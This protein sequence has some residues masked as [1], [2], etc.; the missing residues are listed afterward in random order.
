MLVLRKVNWNVIEK[1]LSFLGGD[2]FKELVI[3]FALGIAT[4]FFSLYNYH[5]QPWTLD[6]AFITF[7]Y[8]E[9]FVEGKGI[10]YNPGEYVEGYTCFLWLI[11]L[12]LVKKLGFDIVIASKVLG[13][14]FTFLSLFLISRTHKIVKD[15]PWFVSFVSVLVLGSFGT[16]TAWAM[17]GM[18]TS[19]TGF[20]VLCVFLLYGAITSRRLFYY[21]GHFLV[22]VFIALATMARIDAGIILPPILLCAGYEALRKGRWSAPIL[23]VFGF[24]V[25]YFPYFL[26]RYYYYGWLLPNTFYVKVGSSW[27]QIKRGFD[28][29]KY[30][31]LSSSILW[32]PVIFTQ[33]VSVRRWGN[34]YLLIAGMGIAVIFQFLYVVI[35]GGDCMPAYR[36][37]APVA[38][39][40]AMLVGYGL[41]IRGFSRWRA[42]VVLLIIVCF[43]L[44]QCYNDKSLYDRILSDRVAEI[45]KESGEWL[46]AN[47]PPDSLLATNTAGSVA[48]YSRL[49]V[50]DMLGL[51]DEHIAHRYIPSLGKGYA[52][53]EKG[54]GKYVLSRKP[55]YIMFGSASGSKTPRFLSDKEMAGDKEFIENYVYRTHSLPSGRVLHIYERKK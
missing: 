14:I 34:K 45:G 30:F 9:N 35:V 49:R 8:S 27:D 16:F 22:G 46:R 3:W 31:L 5:L 42:S 50:I 39:I 33:L 40:I 44:W 47:V 13:S 2:L 38:P 17:S 53:H 23:V 25:V 10:V 15:T 55:D 54:D 19:M 4:V 1:W 43:N 18:E 29:T 11:L 7:R 52:G 41:S 12:A 26:W 48:Y 51:N 28:Y 21:L 20:L 37:F 6:D 36:F 24:G 32:V